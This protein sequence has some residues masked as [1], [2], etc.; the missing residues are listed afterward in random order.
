MSNNL[1][2][3]EFNDFKKKCLR[4]KKLDSKR[5]RK[6]YKDSLK[7]KI[8]FKTIGDLSKAIFDDEFL[9]EKLEDNEKLAFFTDL[10][11]EQNMTIALEKYFSKS[12]KSYVKDRI[13][14]TTILHNPYL[15]DFKNNKNLLNEYTI[16]KKEQLYA[17]NGLTHVKEAHLV[18]GITKEKFKRFSDHGFIVHKTTKGFRK[19]GRR[20]EARYYD[21][22]EINKISAEQMQDW[23]IKISGKDKETYTLMLEHIKQLE[24]KYNIKY[25]NGNWY[26]DTQIIKNFT[27]KIYDVLEK[28]TDIYPIEKMETILLNRI[29][30]YITRFAFADYFELEV[31]DKAKAIKK[32]KDHMIKNESHI[33]GKL[34]FFR[35]Y[36]KKENLY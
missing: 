4:I 11:S 25:H 34:N 28:H 36:K 22:H 16:Y 8:T 24:D 35:V 33:Y 29:N 13:F 1:S 21:Y 32:I 27:F 30:H 17:Q 20:L 10:Y 9:L 15:K 7:L 23:D 14:E 12:N 2:N 3:N 18:I 5:L 6:I 19:W 31:H 26:I